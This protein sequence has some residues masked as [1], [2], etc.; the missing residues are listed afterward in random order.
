MSQQPHRFKFIYVGC[1]AGVLAVSPEFALAQDSE[2]IDQQDS[3]APAQS[4]AVVIDETGDEPLA[5]SGKNPGTVGKSGIWF[6]P[7]ITVQHT[8]T[9]NAKLDPTGLNDQITEIMPGFRLVSDTARIK[10]FADYTLRSAHYARGTTS[11]QI[12]HN[13]FAR[14]T[15][16]IAENRFFV[17]VTGVAM[18][19]PISAF[20]APGQFYSAN[21][22]MTQTSTFRVSPYLRGELT[23]GLNYE[24]RY[25]VQ[26]TR[27]DTDD[28]SNVMVNDWRLHLGRK[29]TGQ[30]WGWG[31]D[32]TQE[33]ADYAAG[34]DIKTTAFR[35]R[36]NY[37]PL[38]QLQL[39]AI[40]GVES[41]NQLSPTRKSHSIVGFGVNWRPSER[42]RLSV[43]RESRYFGESHKATFE[44]RTARS[45]WQYSDSRGVVTGL[46]ARSGSM[47]PL[48]DLL[49]GFYARMEP[50][51]DRRAQLVRTEI[52]RMGLPPDMQVFPDFL[53]S[54]STLERLQQLSF[55]LLGQ[56]STLTV[57]VMRSNTQLLDNSLQLGDD[58]DRDSKI[59]QRGWSLMLGHRLTPGT[60]INFSFG[61]TRSMGV[62]S[63]LETRTRPFIVGWNTLV[64][65]RTN[66]GIQL[67]RVL[68]DGNVNSYGESAIMGLIT[69]RF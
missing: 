33:N 36:L 19:Q 17:D 30:V 52:A 67:R 14:G 57:L 66:I 37:M 22:N 34:R 31:L 45:V 15:A 5:Q 41:A 12:W 11:D 48:S 64:A 21:S 8:V 35:A 42:T 32:A 43:E 59:R 24:I 20:G 25:G 60:S 13:L 65:R 54:S 53:T 44:Y 61:E 10:G 46:G 3:V 29:L 49:D 39:A 58:F 9:N 50:N 26:D 38:S 4:P 18:V 69:H 28:R 56:R 16:E 27:Y 47:G 1:I 40:G 6:E 51:V 2:L 23:G 55:A 62:N 63:G 68:S 7:N